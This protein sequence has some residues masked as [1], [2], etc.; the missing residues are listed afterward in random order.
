MVHIRR[1]CAG[2]HAGVRFPYLLQDALSGEC[3]LKG[4]SGVMEKVG[5]MKK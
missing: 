5:F 2:A 4:F 3:R 1:A